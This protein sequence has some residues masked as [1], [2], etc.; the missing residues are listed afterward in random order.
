MADQ[1]RVE[2]ETGLGNF[3]IELTQGKTPTTVENFLGGKR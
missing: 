3:T 1:P 2:F